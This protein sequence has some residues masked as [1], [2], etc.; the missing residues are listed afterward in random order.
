M[1]LKMS[2]SFLAFG[3]IFLI[4][5]TCFSGIKSFIKYTKKKH[6]FQEV[7]HRY[8]LESN[9][10]DVLI[11]QLKEMQDIDYWE[12]CLKKSFGYIGKKEVVYGVL[13]TSEKNSVRNTMLEN[14]RKE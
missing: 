3:I 4:V 2:K 6:A 13:V 1:K 10:R 5:H 7:V 14:R 12:L 8:T 11:R 9:K